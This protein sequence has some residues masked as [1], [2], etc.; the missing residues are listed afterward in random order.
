MS[1]VQ[2]FCSNLKQYLFPAMLN[3]FKLIPLTVDSSTILW[4][5]GFSFPKAVMFSWKLLTAP[6]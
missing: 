1:F 2:N 3:C 5:L 6:Y 4:L